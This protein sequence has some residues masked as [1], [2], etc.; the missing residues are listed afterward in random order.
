ML[1]Q[2]AFHIVLMMVLS[3]I[4][5]QLGNVFVPIQIFHS[6]RACRHMIISPASPEKDFPTS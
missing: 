5:N 1:Q 3:T 2:S 4:V 6:L